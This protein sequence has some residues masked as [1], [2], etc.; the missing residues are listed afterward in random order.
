MNIAFE[1]LEKIQEIYN[2]LVLL[3]DREMNKIEKKWLNTEELANYIGYSKESIKKMIK[4]EEFILEL[5]YYKKH[6]KNIFD[7]AEIDKWIMSSNK[8]YK[9]NYELLANNILKNVA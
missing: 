6:R 8:P 9:K 7:K 1:N 2:I 4:E 5:H 3:R